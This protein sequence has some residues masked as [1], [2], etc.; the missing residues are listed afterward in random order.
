MTPGSKWRH[1][2]GGVYRLVACCR[3]EATK[4]PHVI[5]VLDSAA[6]PYGEYWCRPLAEWTQ[7][8]APGKRRFELMKE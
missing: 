1:W 7:E 3:L 2:K 6:Y 5:Y 4:E 8:V